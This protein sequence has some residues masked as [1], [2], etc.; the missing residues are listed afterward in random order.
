MYTVEAFDQYDN[1]LGDVTALSTFAI[2]PDGT[3]DDPTATC[4]STVSGPAHGDGDLRSAKTATSDLTVSPG[5]L[6]HIV[7][8]PSSATVDP[9]VGQTYSIEAFDALDNPITDVT[10]STTLTIDGAGTCDNLAHTCTAAPAGDYTVTATYSGKTDTGTLTINELPPVA[11]DDT[12]DSIFEDG[13]PKNVDVIANDSDPNGDALTVSGTTDGAHGTVAIDVSGLFVTYTPEADWSGSDSFTYTISDG[14]GGFD[15]ASVDVTVVPQNDPPSFSLLG[16]QTVLEDAGPQTVVGF[17][18]GSPGPP[19]ESGQTLSYVIDSDSNPGLFTVEPSISSAGDLTFTAGPDLNGSATITVHAVDSGPNG[20]GDINFSAPQTFD[21]N[22]TAVDDAPVAVD[23]GAPYLVKQGVAITISAAA[24]VLT[25]DTDIDTPSD[26][27]TAVL[28]TQPA[29]GTVTLNPNGSFTYTSSGIIGPESFT[30]HVN[31]GSLD[32]NIATV[33]MDVYLNHVPTAVSDIV[34]VVSGSGYVALGVLVNDYA[35]NPDP[36][37]TLLITSAS[38]PIHGTVSI[39]GGGTGLK[40]RPA[41]GFIGSDVFTYTITDGTFTSTGSV[42]VKV[43]K[44]T[45]KPVATAPVQTIG[46]QTMGTSTVKIHLVWSGTDKG[47]GV[48]KYELWWSTDGHSYKKIKTTSASSSSATLTLNH[49]YRFRVRAIDKKGNIGSFAYGP[50]FKFVRY[51]ET[52]LVYVTAWSTVNSASYSSGHARTTSTAGRSATLTT[53]GRTFTW[54][55]VKGPTRGT[56]DVYVDGVLKVHLNLNS[57]TRT[58]RKV[59]WSITF[60]SSAAH[61][62]KIVYTGPTTRRVEVD[63]IVVLR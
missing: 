49:V 39:T 21:V 11:A 60:A 20:A 14:H 27:L 42:L 52:S 34:T 46:S 9:T 25:N 61:S 26:Q 15:T 57:S 37:E 8:S 51:Q 40:Y 48:S 32:S 2:T 6:D 35:A 31:D 4:Q 1:T 54:I 3:C 22:V 63:A 28:D 58:Y 56:A 29:D 5:T 38:H 13:G 47:Y 45:Y 53:T 16:D 10:A 30:Y 23:D 59:I 7:L 18:T 12:A 36:G 41:S 33:S 62:F 17:A 19:D 55:G 24:G 44:D 50:T 43:P